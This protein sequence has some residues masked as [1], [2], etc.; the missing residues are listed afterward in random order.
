TVITLLVVM[1]GIVLSSILGGQVET[2]RIGVIGDTPAAVESIET[3]EAVPVAD[4]A[5]AEQLLRNGD[6]EAVVVSDDSALGFSLIAL[7]SAPDEVVFGLS[8]SPHV[9]LLEEP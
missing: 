9:E 2:T 4:R 8:V 6:V 5:E 1:G 7:S 3:L